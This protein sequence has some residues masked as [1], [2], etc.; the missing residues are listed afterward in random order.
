[1]AGSTPESR[2]NLK[3]FTSFQLMAAMPKAK[4]KHSVVENLFNFKF[5]EKSL[6]NFITNN[7]NHDKFIMK[8]RAKLAYFFHY[9]D[10]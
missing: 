1:M 9:N 2:L 6:N 7:A 3:H 5:Y 10:Q 4:N 8:L